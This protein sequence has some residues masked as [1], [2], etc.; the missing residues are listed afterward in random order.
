[1]VKLQIKLFEGRTA[2]KILGVDEVL[3][4]KWILRT[5]LA[6]ERTGLMWL[7]L[8]QVAGSCEQCNEISGCAKCRQFFFDYLKCC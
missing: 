2:L 4:L 1:M 8:G 7:L 3:I 5:L 6:M